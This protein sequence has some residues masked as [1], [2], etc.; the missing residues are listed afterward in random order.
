MT[1]SD[2][3]TASCAACGAIFL[4]PILLS[5]LQSGSLQKKLYRYIFVMV[6][7]TLAGCLIELVWALFV[8]ASG[9]AMRAALVYLDYADYAFGSIIRA[10]F[11]LYVHEYISMRINPSRIPIRIVLWLEAV[12][13]LL[14]SAAWFGSVPGWLIDI[15]RSMLLPFVS[16][17]LSLATPIINIRV[18]KKREL[19]SLLCYFFI[20]AACYLAESSFEG[21]WVSYLGSAVG[22]AI[23]Y[24]NMHLEL[25]HRFAE[26]EAEMAENRISLMLS[27][28][29]PHFFVQF[30]LRYRGH[31]RRRHRK[32]Q[33]RD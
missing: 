6:L 11:A 5:I 9:G 28:I 16:V 26:Q 22:T 29:Q 18:V 17:V 4:V 21:L 33:N 15:G 19:V 10:A 1:T 23:M 7:F 20:P 2:I 31:M 30:A 3:I 14:V 27:Q 24:V 25:N 12:L 13:I 8:S 32:G